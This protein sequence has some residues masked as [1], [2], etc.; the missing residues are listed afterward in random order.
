[1]LSDNRSYTEKK[2]VNLLCVKWKLLPLDSFWQL[3]EIY[4]A[5]YSEA[6]HAQTFLWYHLRANPEKR[7]AHLKE[8]QK[9]FRRADKE[10]PSIETLRA[11]F[12]GTQESLYPIGTKTDTYGITPSYMSWWDDNFGSCFNENEEF[13]NPS[14]KIEVFRRDHPFWFWLAAAGSLASILAIPLAIV[15]WWYESA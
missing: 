7:T 2:L 4:P 10:V 13:A 5:T 9:Y 12:T 3:L 1:M 15:L 6:E 8:I 14:K 11:A